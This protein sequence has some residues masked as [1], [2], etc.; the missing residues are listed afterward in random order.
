MSP[1]FLRTVAMVPEAR[2]HVGARS[3]EN[4]TYPSAINDCGTVSTASTLCDSHCHLGIYPDRAAVVERAARARVNVI[5]ATSRPSEFRDLYKHFS[6]T[7]LVVV[8]LGFHPEYAG[9]VYVPFEQAIFERCIEKAS[10]IC[11]VGLDGVI[12]EHASPHFGSTPTLGAQI[13]LF[14]FVLTLARR[15]QPLSVHSRRAEGTTLRLLASHAKE[16]VVLHFFSGSI[17]QAARA[18]DQGFYFSAHPNMMSNEEGRQFLQWL[19][20]SLVLLE[21]DG[22]FYPMAGRNIEPADCRTFAEAF[23]SLRGMDGQHVCELIEQN[24]Q[25]F[26]RT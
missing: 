17:E 4:A 2:K 23:A 16:R 24:F 7:P 22:P 13:E 26:V 20:L 21:T 3:Q 5:C 25:Q 18:A 6:G 1:W 11:E 15:D 10:W 19:P 12:S 9:S 14:E 8:G